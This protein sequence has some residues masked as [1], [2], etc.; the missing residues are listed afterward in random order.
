MEYNNKHLAQ[1]KENLWTLI[2]K[3]ERLQSC[4]NTR[5]MTFENAD[6][7]INVFMRKVDAQKGMVETFKTLVKKGEVVYNKVHFESSSIMDVMVS[8]R[9]KLQLENNMRKVFK[10]LLLECKMG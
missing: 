8:K 9:P 4:N 7:D 10:T 3:L 6:F 5:L 1:A 2:I